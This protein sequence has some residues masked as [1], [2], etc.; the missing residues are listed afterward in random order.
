MKAN[1]NFNIGPVTVT[2]EVDAKP[3]TNWLK[4]TKQKNDENKI[5]EYTFCFYLGETGCV[6]EYATIK[7]SI[8]EVKQKIDDP[9][10]ILKATHYGLTRPSI[11]LFFDDSQICSK[12]Q[13]SN[14][15]DEI[16]K[17]DFDISIK[18]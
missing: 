2:K 9:E 18:I 1:I 4:N 8:K 15:Y 12:I 7:T 13:E 6:C 14:G 5:K 16:E 17:E 11:S 3:L 10:L